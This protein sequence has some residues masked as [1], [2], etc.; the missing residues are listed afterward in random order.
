MTRL[1]ARLAATIFLQPQPGHERVEVND[2]GADL[3]EPA[4]EMFGA[5]HDGIALS[6]VAGGEFRH[7]VPEDDAAFEFVRPRRPDSGLGRG[8]QHVVAAATQLARELGDVDLGSADAVGVVPAD[9][10]HDLHGVCIKT[11]AACGSEW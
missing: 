1:P 11:P 6:L 8:D 7:R 2:V 10:L 4:V 5:A 9:G 3:A